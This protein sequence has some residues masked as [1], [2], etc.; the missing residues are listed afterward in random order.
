[1]GS[2]DGGLT[3]LEGILLG[4][5][6]LLLGAVAIHAAAGPAASPGGLIYPVLGETGDCL[7]LSGDVYGYALVNGSVG[8][9][10]LRCDVPDPSKMGSVA[11]SVRLF[12]GDMGSVDM[13]RATVEVATRGRVER[14]GRTA[15]APVLPGNWT[16]VRAGH[17]IPFRQADDDLLLEPGERFDLLVYPSRAL[18]P[19][20]AFRVS[21]IPPGSVPLTIERTVPPRIVPV[22]DLG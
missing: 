9:A 14:L 13:S 17:T 10:D 19:G 1:M 6:A 8:G 12:V 16:V 11:C 3:V 4:V 21:I 7:V 18:S 22:M 5:V 20:E 2:T 15:E